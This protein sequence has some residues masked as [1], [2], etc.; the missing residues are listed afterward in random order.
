MQP[1]DR[2]VDLV[3]VG[4]DGVMEGEGEFQG[5]FGVRQPRRADVGAQDLGAVVDVR[6]VAPGIA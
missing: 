2:S 6:V 4:A 1:G 3:V 5:E